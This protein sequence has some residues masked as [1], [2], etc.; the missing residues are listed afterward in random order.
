ML[1]INGRISTYL[2]LDCL[3]YKFSTSSILLQSF[4]MLIITMIRY[5]A[6]MPTGK[7]IQEKIMSWSNT[8]IFHCTQQM[9][10]YQASIRN[11]CQLIM[12]IITNG[13]FVMLILSEVRVGFNSH[14]KCSFYSRCD[15]ILFATDKM[16]YWV[17]FKFHL[18]FTSSYR[19]AK[20]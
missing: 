10:V 9:L 14:P 13:R 4:E 20:V 3:R 11:N 1:F 17:D 12:K 7:R 19:A 6:L 8:Y 5:I 2:R 16:I 15:V 18:R